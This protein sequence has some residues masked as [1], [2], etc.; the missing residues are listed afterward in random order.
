MTEP[1]KA[2]RLPTAI[3][4]IVG[5]CIGSG[6]FFKSDN[7]LEATGGSVPLGILVFLLG[8]VGIIFGGLS[9]GQLAARTAQPGGLVAYAAEFVGPSFTGGVGWFQVFLYFPTLVAAV[10]RAVGHYF[11]SLFSISDT[12]EAQCLAGFLFFTLCFFWNICSAKLGGILQN[13]ATALKLL[14]LL[15]IAVCGL[16]LGKP[17]ET[18]ELSA[19]SLV[20]TGWISAIGPI[21]FAYDGWVIATAISHEVKDARRN[22]PRALLIAPLFVTC[23]YILYFLGVSSL[24][25]PETVRAMGDRHV[26]F[27]AGRLLGPF[28]AK[29]M[30]LFILIAVAGTLNGVILGYLRLPY[31][32]A[33]RGLLPLSRI[34]AGPRA[35][36]RALPAY[37]ASCV[38][39]ALNYLSERYAWLP[40]A[41]VSEI[42]IVIGY[43]LY[44]VLY[45]QV[46]RLWK[47]GEINGFWRGVVIP[48]LALAGAG[49]V[50]WGGLQSG[51]HLFYAGGCLLVIALGFL[52]GGRMNRAV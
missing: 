11:C 31:A 40:N 46:I 35:F 29:V 13:A 33:E 36:P 5:I 25:G 47:H 17:G 7:I 6:I 18:I 49:I 16:F 8:A 45:V 26:A 12:L 41:D 24:L 27:L 43:L 32:L 39:T 48:A 30:L 15:L 10:S 28:G 20:A 51:A 34:F 14:P 21:A 38:W 19:G 50:L 42:P 3:A 4:M 2:Y 1:N 23:V 22:M 52:Y 37:A 44:A 9:I